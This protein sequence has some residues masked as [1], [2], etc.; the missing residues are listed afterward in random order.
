[1]QSAKLYILSFW[2]AFSITS[3]KSTLYAQ[4]PVIAFE[5]GKNNFSITAV[6]QA[7]PFLL[8]D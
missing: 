8:S 4:P 2:L 3:F 5:K 7:T 6:G 1:M